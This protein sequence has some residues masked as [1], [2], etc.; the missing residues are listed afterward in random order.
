M[1]RARACREK[2]RA[3]LNC[4]RMGGSATCALIFPTLFS[5]E[6]PVVILTSSNAPSEASKA[7]RLGANAFIRKP[8]TFEELV[9][10]L[11]SFK[12]F[13][14]KFQSCRRAPRRSRPDRA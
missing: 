7:Y 12:V 2:R 14:L 9:E 4:G 6:I 11:K 13:G 3:S 8:S 10:I 5:A 1:I